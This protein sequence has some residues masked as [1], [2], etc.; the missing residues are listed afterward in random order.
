MRGAGDRP[1]QYFCVYVEAF[2]PS[3][4]CECEGEYVDVCANAFPCSNRMRDDDPDWTALGRLSWG[5]KCS[6]RCGERTCND[7]GRP[8]NSSGVDPRDG[9]EQEGKGPIWGRGPS[10]A[11]PSTLS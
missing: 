10:Q 3:D 4:G 1:P 7:A 11:L 8:E 9:R 5:R 6:K 2:V